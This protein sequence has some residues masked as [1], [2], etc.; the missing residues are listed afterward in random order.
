MAKSAGVITITFTAGTAGFVADVARAKSQVREFG[1]TT[2]FNMAESSAAVRALEGNFGN[3]T[4]AVSRFLSVTLGMGPVLQAAFP[5][6]GAV[7]LG[8]AI[9]DTGQ[10]LSKF[11]K[12]IEQ[13]PERIKG[14]FREI[15]GPLKATNDELAVSN[16]RLENE[17]AKLE[18]KRQNTLKVALLEAAAAGDKLAES[19]DKDLKEINRLFEEQQVGFWARLVGQGGTSDITQFFGGETQTG[20]FRDR[21]A[22]ITEEGQARIDAAAKANDLQAQTAARTKLNA[23]LTKAYGDAL[24]WV[25]EKLAEAEALQDKRN[26]QGG[27]VLVMGGIGSGAQP[28]PIADQSARLELLRDA[29]RNLRE[30]LRFVGLQGENTSLTQRADALKA[31]SENAKLERPFENKLA[32]LRQQLDAVRLKSQSVGAPEGFQILTKAAGEAGK[33]IEEVDKALKAAHA[34]PLTPAQESALG[35]LVLQRAGLEYETERQNK[36]RETTQ[37]L[38]AQIHA[39][40]DLTAA[41]GKSFEATRRV[42]I[43]T[44][45]IRDS[46]V[47]FNNYNDP[48]WMKAHADEVSR[49]RSL[50]GR[51]FDAQHGAQTTQA[52]SALTQQVELER[53]LAQVQSLGAEAIARLTLAYKLR[54][55]VAKGATQEQI[56]A[57]IQLFEATRQTSAASDLSQLRERAQETSRLAAAQLQGA[58]AVRKAALENK[59][60]QL[61]REGKSPDVIN[62]ERVND[63]LERQKELSAEALRTGQA[64]QNQLETIDLQIAALKKAASEQGDS[65]AIELSLR[66]LEKE[67]LKTLAEQARAMGG[68]KDG[69][70]SVFLEMAADAQTA[71]QVVADSLKSAIDQ[72]NDAL[73]KLATGQKVDFGRVLQQQGEALVKQGLKSGEAALAKVLFPDKKPMG[74]TELKPTGRPGDPVHVWVE[75]GQPEEGGEETG[76]SV[77]GAVQGAAGV[78]GGFLGRVGGFL[79]PVIAGAFGGKDVTPS[80]SSTISYDLPG[81]ADGGPVSP[82]EAYIV[83]ERGPETFVPSQHGTVMSNALAQRTFGGDGGS[84]AYYTIHV[85]GGDP[86]DN[87]IRFR[88]ALQEIHGSAIRTSVQANHD[89]KRRTP[90][91]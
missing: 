81:R 50:Y 27:P 28:Q 90:Q 40:E 86:A 70:R 46:N 18:G 5:V 89:L 66:D 39:Q 16:A 29:A 78:L 73:A 52:T 45:L 62:Q 57:E 87:E 64:Y 60:A 9:Y 53:S 77:Q 21:I 15:D 38:E 2:K 31:A 71:A 32:D 91:R 79:G 47:G 30:E 82:G 59:Y 34:Q 20:G 49:L 13:A 44:Q 56:R 12:D 74:P 48:T 75:N 69:I 67:R 80:V 42:A 1:Q 68:I 8:K 26:K 88:K 36:L 11:I 61:A 58:E 23:D 7:L 84:H 43:E 85:H 76:S 14:L 3:T 37:R 4:R 33:A 17:I 25:N 72:A 24:A 54:E 83:G 63:V 65:L 19:L 10:R 6:I 51:E 22:R 35:S 41:I 55:L